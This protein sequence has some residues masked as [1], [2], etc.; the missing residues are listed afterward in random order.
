MITY[1]EG[2]DDDGTVSQAGDVSASS[3]SGRNTISKKN[4]A[5]LLYGTK[6]EKEGA[7]KITINVKRRKYEKQNDNC[8]LILSPY[9]TYAAE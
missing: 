4:A 2:G 6:N 7:D 5:A 3:S 1:E 9:S 8:I